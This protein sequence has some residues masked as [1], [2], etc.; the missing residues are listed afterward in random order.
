MVENCWK[1]SKIFKKIVKMLVRSCFLI[2][3]IKSLKGRNSLG[4]LCNVKSKSPEWVSQWQG[5]LLSCC[6][7]L[8]KFYLIHIVFHCQ[9]ANGRGGGGVKHCNGHPVGV[10]RLANQLHLRYLY[11]N[12]Y[13]CICICA[14]QTNYTSSN[15]IW[16]LICTYV[17]IIVLYSYFNIVTDIQFKLTI[18]N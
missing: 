12:L 17:T 10:D 3:L 2:T 4:S 5:H 1:M 16:T 14:L 15:C 6:G 11:S 13:L 9:K 8:K 18:T 7:Q